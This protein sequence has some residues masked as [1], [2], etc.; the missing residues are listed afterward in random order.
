VIVRP[1]SRTRRSTCHPKQPPPS[2]QWGRL[3]LVF[4]EPTNDL[5][6]ETLDLLQERVAECQIARDRHLPFGAHQT[7]RHF[8]DRA[9]FL[10]GQAGVDG[11]QDTLMVVGVEPGRQPGI[12]AAHRALGCRS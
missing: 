8:V 1:I 7:A 4:D 6:L 9:D 11:L 12:A 10:D 2:Y 3:A 5:D